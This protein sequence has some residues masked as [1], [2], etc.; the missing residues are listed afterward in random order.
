MASS[1]CCKVCPGSDT[2]TDLQCQVCLSHGGW[3]GKW[4]YGI[5]NLPSPKQAGHNWA[6]MQLMCEE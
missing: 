5:R 4:Q 1:G 2:G 3:Q 6:G